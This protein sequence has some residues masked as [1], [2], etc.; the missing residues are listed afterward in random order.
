MLRDHTSVRAEAF[1]FLHGIEFDVVTNS[2]PGR[3]GVAGLNYS[4][5]SDDGDEAEE[6]GDGR[7]DDEG[8]GPVDGNDDGP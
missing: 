1:R 4:E 5:G 3:E 6:I 2:E 7:R 8:D